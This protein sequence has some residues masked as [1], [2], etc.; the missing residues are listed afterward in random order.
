MRKNN[1]I[2]ICTK[3]FSFIFTL[4][5]VTKHLMTYAHQKIGLAYG[6]CLTKQ[7]EYLQYSTL[8]IEQ[9]YD[10]SKNQN[11]WLLAHLNHN[12]KIDAYTKQ[13]NDP[14]LFLSFIGIS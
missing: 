9:S 10:K 12:R 2:H 13:K 5:H 7:N 8:T 1:I 11:I 14:F 3:K 6:S 4:S